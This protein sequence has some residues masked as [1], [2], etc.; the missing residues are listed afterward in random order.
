MDPVLCISEGI[1]GKVSCLSWDSSSKLL[2]AAVGS[3]ALVWDV[4]GAKEGRPDS[5]YVL[6][7]FEQGSC[8]SCLAFQPNGTLLVRA[9]ANA[10][11][12]PLA[13]LLWPLLV[14]RALGAA[15]ASC[16]PACLPACLL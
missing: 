2:A 11:P 13:C 16:L 15:L 10:R 6:I 1:D 12:R 7:G 3:E 4:A 5:S 9:R 8:V 14:A